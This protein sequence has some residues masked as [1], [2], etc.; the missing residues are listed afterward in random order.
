MKKK[1]FTRFLTPNVLTIVRFVLTAL[2]LY[3]L[4][5][6]SFFARVVALSL[7]VCAV[8]TDYFD[9]FIA[10]KY[11]LISNFGKI[12]D[13]IADKFLLLGLFTAFSH[14]GMYHFSWLL[15]I[16]I[17]E[18]LVTVV[19]LILLFRGSV[20]AAAKLGKYKVVT[21]VSC[22]VLSWATLFTREY[23]SNLC[24]YDWLEHLEL[25]M[26][27]LLF[28]AII[29]TVYSGITFLFANQRQFADTGFA[30]M[31]GTF[32]FIGYTPLLPGTAGTAGAVGVYFLIKG[33]VLYSTYV[34]IVLILGTWSARC[35]SEKQDN[36]DPKEVVIDEVAGFLITMLFVPFTVLTV[37]CGFLLFRFFD[38]VK[39]W[40]IRQVEQLPYGYGIMLDD[41]IAGVFSNF[42]LQLLYYKVFITFGG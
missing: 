19:R 30:R 5:V 17:R 8:I 36:E 14:L 33:S 20:I 32:L 1:L 25:G 39:P 24:I 3:Y 29:L 41:I 34:A 6:P 26:Y 12:A 10:R 23:G 40:P 31:I 15:P 11:D 27:V 4:F 42:I 38:I 9:G 37:I 7:F 18:V 2:L 28:C 16:I 35:V 13:P 21:Q 22:L